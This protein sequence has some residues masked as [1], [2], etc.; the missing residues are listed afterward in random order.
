MEMD[1]RRIAAGVLAGGAVI[2]GW[3]RYYRPGVTSAPPQWER[4]LVPIAA[5][6][7]VIGLLVWQIVDP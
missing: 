5:V 6:V 7:L 4:N 2:Y 3:L 1:P